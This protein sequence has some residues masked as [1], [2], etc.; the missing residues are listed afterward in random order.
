MVGFSVTKR[1]KFKI[2]AFTEREEKTGCV[3][4]RACVRERV[5]ERVPE[6]VCECVS[7]GERE[8]A[9]SVLVNFF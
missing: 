1:P 2:E 3:C 4:V 8:N 9:G 7:E 5:R 6:R